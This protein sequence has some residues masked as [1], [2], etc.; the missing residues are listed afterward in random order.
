MQ[1]WRT[2]LN[3]VQ[4]TWHRHRPDGL[5]ERHS[6]PSAGLDLFSKSFRSIAKSSIF[7]QI[8][9][10]SRPTLESYKAV[11]SEIDQLT[12]EINR[13]WRTGDWLPMYYS[14]NTLDRPEMIALHRL[15]QFC[16]VSSLHDGMNLVAKEFV[17]SRNDEDG[18]LVLSSFTGA[19]REMKD[20]ILVNPFSIEESAIGIGKRLKCLA[21]NACGVC[22]GCVAS[23]DEQ[24]LPLG[25]KI[26]VG[27]NP[28]G[29]SRRR[30]GHRMTGTKRVRKAQPLNEAGSEWVERIKSA[31]TI[32]LFLDFDG[33]LSPIVEHPGL[34]KIDPE[35]RDVFDPAVSGMTSI[36]VV[37]GRALDDVSERAGSWHHLCRKSWS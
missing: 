15:A 18:A 23:G 13:R 29:I 19:A 14:K 36:S 8:G 28:T 3:R 27:A 37:S 9:V 16:V 34:A 32:S 22:R 12:V 7:V 10:P 20:A 4:A 6:G 31:Q 11:E 26:L 25:G 33:T 5:Y 24:H 1:S 21:M 30:G 2:R 35:I 17:A